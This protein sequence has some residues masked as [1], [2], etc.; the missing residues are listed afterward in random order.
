MGKRTTLRWTGLWTAAL[1]AP[2]VAAVVAA[3]EAPSFAEAAAGPLDAEAEGA[4]RAPCLSPRL[5][6]AR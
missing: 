3:V 6:R 5:A 2:V 1:L 4:R